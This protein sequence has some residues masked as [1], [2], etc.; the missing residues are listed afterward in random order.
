LKDAEGVVMFAQVVS[1]G[2]YMESERLKVNWLSTDNSGT[3]KFSLLFSDVF[4]HEK[5]KRSFVKCIWETNKQESFQ[6]VPQTDVDWV[7]GAF[8]D[9]NLHRN[10]AGKEED[11]EDREEEEEEEYFDDDD[12]EGASSSSSSTS[13]NSFGSSKDKNS[14]LAVG[15]TH[16]DRSFVAKG[17]QVGVFRLTDDASLEFDTTLPPLKT[18]SG[19]P[20]TP[21]RVCFP[22]SL[23]LIPPSFLGLTCP[24]LSFLPTD[25]VTSTR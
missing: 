20:F 21:T 5:F 8:G 11:D 18:A 23:L 6:N 13:K 19:Q 25:D 7:V 2:M 17:D 14:C 3:W 24:L 4:N 10:A 1:N 22:S 9:I 12:D 15:Y 16:S